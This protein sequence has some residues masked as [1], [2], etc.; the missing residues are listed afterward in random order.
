MAIVPEMLASAA[1]L[2]KRAPLPV[3]VDTQTLRVVTKAQ[4]AQLDLAGVHGARV[5]F[6]RNGD[7]I[8]I[9]YTTNLR[10]RLDAL[11]L[12]PDAVLLLLEG[13]KL[14]EGSLHRHFAQHRVPNTEWFRYVEE[15]KTYISMK[16]NGIPIP[17]S[18]SGHIDETKAQEAVRIAGFHAGPKGEVLVSREGLLQAIRRTRAT[19]RVSTS[20]TS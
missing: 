5:Y 15:I 17:A 4:T 11:C 19:A 16:L 8:K 3:A 10:N 1:S 13:G 12:R 20:P 14:L 6:I 2:A 7:R 18:R 9:G